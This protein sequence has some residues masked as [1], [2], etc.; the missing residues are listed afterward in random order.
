MQVKKKEL[1][2]ETRVNNKIESQNCTLHPEGNVYIK[3]DIKECNRNKILK[4]LLRKC[5]KQI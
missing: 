4:Q 1:N 3:C 5:D 2:K